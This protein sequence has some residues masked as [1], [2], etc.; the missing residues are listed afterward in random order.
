MISNTD[1]FV[2]IVLVLAVAFSIIGISI[3][4]IRMLGG[5]VETVKIA[6]TMMKS[7]ST[8][9][10]KFTDDYDYLMDQIKFILNT[11]SKFV[12]GVLGPIVKFAGFA[13]S[14][15]DKKKKK[16]KSKADEDKDEDDNDED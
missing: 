15:G 4:V 10:E 11:I 2:K 9:V 12:N 16:S 3:Q 14:F 8:L 6:N 7:A 1:D 13:K 5:F